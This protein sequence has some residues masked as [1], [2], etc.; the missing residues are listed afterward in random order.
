MSK[1]YVR[2]GII[3]CGLMGREFASAAARWAHLLDFDVAPRIV[4][5]C[6]TN[7]AML[8]W[9]SDS[10]DTIQIATQDYTDLLNA[11]EID[12][13]YCAVPHNLHKQFYTD[14]I[15]AGKHLLGEK[16]F[17]IDQAANTHIIEATR[18]HPDVLVRCS[19]EFPFFPGVQAILR[20]IQE[21][22]FG[23]ILEVQA[24]FLHS[25]DLDPRKPINWKRRVATNGEYGCMGDLGMHVL[26]IP[27]R[28]HW[29]PHNLRALLSK[30]VTQRPEHAGPDAPMVPCETWDNAVLA[31]EVK[32]ENQHFPMLLEIKRIAPGETNTWYIRV[33][34]TRFS[35]EFSTKYPKTLRTMTYTPGDTQAW[36]AQDLGSESAYPT[37]TGNIFEFGFSDSILQMWAAFCDE[38]AHPGSMRQPFYCVTPEETRR[39]HR[40]LTAALT[41]HHQTQVI[42]L[43]SED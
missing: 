25:S 37:I 43:N 11:R 33:L 22:R 42:Q 18:R 13:I 30:V 17:G 12:A 5:I 4:G 36:Q 15:E 28:A 40:I 39:S 27:L 38:L 35:A 19:S 9:F 24:G 1:R 20:F 3:G 32:N 34:G 21:Q 2:F 16:P 7:P 31:C 14:I 10:L 8:R 6:D 26:H 23:T 29:F 41:S